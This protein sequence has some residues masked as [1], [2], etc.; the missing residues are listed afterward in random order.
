M[1]IDE[2]W[3][4]L[5]GH[6]RIVRDE[7]II[8]HHLPP[9]T[10]RDALLLAGA[11]LLGVGGRGGRVLGGGAEVL[12]HEVAAQTQVRDVDALQVRGQVVVDILEVAHLAHRQL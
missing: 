12:P 1:I 11:L 6:V 4:W 2:S 7:M 3:L 10:D 5:E 8:N 9:A